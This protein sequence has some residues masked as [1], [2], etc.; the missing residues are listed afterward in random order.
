M[1]LILNLFWVVLSLFLL[2]LWHHLHASPADSPQRHPAAQ[3]ISLA[4][5]LLIL[6]PVISVS[7]DLLAAQ[8]PAE[9]CSLRKASD[10]ASDHH[11]S[12]HDMAAALPAPAAFTHPPSSTPL[13]A[14]DAPG[15]IFL[16]LAPV[17]H[18]RPPP[19]SL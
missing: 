5:V 14:W 8:S 11:T 4:L 6:F 7:D 18:N 2:A 3:L 13:R 19:S 10:A 16:Q 17:I 15:M 9:T 12:H 1:E